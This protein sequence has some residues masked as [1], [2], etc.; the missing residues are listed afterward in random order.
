VLQPVNAYRD[1]KV[2]GVFVH[3]FVRRFTEDNADQQKIKKERSL[4]DIL[5]GLF[6]ENLILELDDSMLS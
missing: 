3:V 2:V 6:D 1:K 4:E 5:K